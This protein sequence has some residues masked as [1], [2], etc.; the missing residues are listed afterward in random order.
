MTTPTKFD[1]RYWNYRTKSW[2]TSTS[3]EDLVAK[4]YATTR[5]DENGRMLFDKDKVSYVEKMHEH[6]D[7]QALSGIVQ[8]D[9]V[10]AAWAIGNA[11]G[12]IWNL[13]SD[14]TISKIIVTGSLFEDEF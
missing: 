5:E 9:P 7:V 2:Q 14:H 6:G 4:V 11:D 8:W 12:E 10:N 1:Y 13:L 3:A